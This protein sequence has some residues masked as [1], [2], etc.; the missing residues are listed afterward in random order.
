MF[1]EEILRKRA[2]ITV[3][4]NEVSSTQCVGG[5][6]Q[7]IDVRTDA[8]GRVAIKRLCHRDSLEGHDSDAGLPQ[9]TKDALKF[10]DKKHVANG[11]LSEILFKLRLQIGR[12]S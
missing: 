10:G 12:A 11:V 8:H 4:E 3:G 9:E 1:R 5:G 6:D 7:N 2:R